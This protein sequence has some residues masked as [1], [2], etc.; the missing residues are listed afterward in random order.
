MPGEN[1]YGEILV[2]DW[3]RRVERTDHPADGSR[4]YRSG[5]GDAEFLLLHGV[6]NSGAVF[7]PLMPALAEH[8]AAV[9]PTMSPDLLAGP[10][11]GPTESMTP[12]VEWLA[13]IAP[14]PWRLVGHSMGGVLTGLIL[15]SHPELVR[16][17]VTINAPLPGVIDRLRGR[18]TIDRTGR[19]LLFMKLLSRVTTIGRPRLPGFL[20]GPELLIVRN[21][22]RGFI[23]AP[24]ELDTRV[25][26][27][28]VLRSRTTDGHDFLGLATEMP[29][30]ESDPF[31]G[32]PVRILLGADDPLV[33]DEDRDA[34][35]AMYPDAEVVDV[36]RCS[37]FAHLEQPR[38][39]LDE[40]LD[41][42]DDATSRTT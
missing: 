20:K 35:R 2:D 27:R 40:I 10:Q 4:V 6:G 17:A 24:G 25:I 13:E 34:V 31:V 30:W 9:A 21:A 18:D 16:G 29:G 32:L 8:G 38:R 14:P 37:H 7:S 36:E 3:W 41:A 1:G 22:L 23:V 42:F 11:G 12:L 19:A 33:P 26:A 28:A 15:R 5:E 39:C